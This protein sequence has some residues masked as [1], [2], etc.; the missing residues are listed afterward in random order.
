MS[1]HQR[2]YFEGRD[3]VSD[4]VLALSDE[5]LAVR[6]PATPDWT[7]T[8]VVAHLTGI[9]DDS[10]GGN[11]DGVG[12]DPW[13]AAQV[14]KRRGRSIQEIVEEWRRLTDDAAEVF[15]SFPPPVTA[16]LIGDFATHEHDIRGGLSNREAR[17]SEA[18][19]VAVEWYARQFTK[20]ALDSGLASI[21]VAAGARE[22]VRGDDEPAVT[23]R[24]EPFEVLR[25]LTGRRTR[26]E[27][28]AL[29][30]SGGDPSPYVEIFSFYG[31]PEASLG[32]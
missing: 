16:S 13:T 5:E 27:V 21:R 2:I 23:V 26:D 11:L 9:I 30:W 1:E 4:L 6:A 8:D 7:V 22:W 29:A 10:L 18:V 24:G 12:S 31:L 3:R 15:A 17:D 14:E 28:L 32:E 25:S 20:K 19:D